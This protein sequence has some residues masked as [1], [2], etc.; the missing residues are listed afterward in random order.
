MGLRTWFQRDPH[1]QG[2][3]SIPISGRAHPQGI[4]FKC[5]ASTVAIGIDQ[6]KTAQMTAAG[7]TAQ[8]KL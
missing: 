4:Y 3:Q 7:D 2:L 1:R 5:R 6:K 8:P